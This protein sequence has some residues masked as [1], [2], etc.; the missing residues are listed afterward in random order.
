MNLSLFTGFLFLPFGTS[1]HIYSQARYI[2]KQIDKYHRLMTDLFDIFKHLN[3]R[4]AH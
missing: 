4:S 1:V 3:E 2:N